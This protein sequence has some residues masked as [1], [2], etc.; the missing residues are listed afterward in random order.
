MLLQRSFT[1]ENYVTRLYLKH[2]RTRYC[3]DN[4]NDNIKK[5]KV[6]TL[7]HNSWAQNMFADYF[8]NSSKIKIIIYINTKYSKRQKQYN[9]NINEVVT[10]EFKK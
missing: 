7:R 4:K 9:I 5:L 10:K 2:R 3:E 8:G 1:K 6:D